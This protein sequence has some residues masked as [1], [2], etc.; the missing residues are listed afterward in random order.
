MYVCVYACMYVC[1]CMYVCMYVCVYVCMYVCTYLRT[2]ADTGLNLT[3]AITENGHQARRCSG[4]VVGCLGA[5]QDPI[6]PRVFDALRC[7]LSHSWHLKL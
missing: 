2:W 7:I 4:L 3:G 5:A 1:L 6:S